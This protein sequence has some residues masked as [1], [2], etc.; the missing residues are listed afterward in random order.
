VASC[1]ILVTR[2]AD[3]SGRVGRRESLD[4]VI[5]GKR[6]NVELDGSGCTRTNGFN[7]R[8]FRIVMDCKLL[9]DFRRLGGAELLRILLRF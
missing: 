2:L 5:C 3:D 7:S 1:F 4:E 6:W 8:F 9:K